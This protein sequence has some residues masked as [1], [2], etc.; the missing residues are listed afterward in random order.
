MTQHPPERIDLEALSLQ[1]ASEA[2][3]DKIAA[4]VAANLHHL[5]PW[6]PWASPGAGT[7]GAQRDRLQETSAAWD[8]GREYEFL[9]L[10]VPD[11]ELLGVFGLHRRVGPG[12]I[13]LGYWLVEAAVGHGHATTAAKALT[14]VALMLPD[15][16]HVE[17]R[18]DAANT[19]SQR[20][21]ERLGYRLDRV[22]ADDVEAPAELGQSMVW[23]V[24][25]GS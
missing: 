9:A 1:R 5:A 22:E 8:A 6:M 20:V 21:P 4:A 18:C 3:A 19:R 10:R 11:D 13:E 25:R 17:I 24:S 14:D 16:D 12:A 15:V 7:P 23:C 2:D